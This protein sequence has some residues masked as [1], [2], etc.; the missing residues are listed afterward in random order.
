MNY[1]DLAAVPEILAVESLT[2][3]TLTVL[4][5][6]GDCTGPVKLRH[7]AQDLGFPKPSITR[8]TLSLARSKLVERRRGHDLRDCLLSLTHEG[9]TCWSKLTGEQSREA[10]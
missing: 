3:R 8:A 10:A 4:L 7:A 1:R 6:L 9:W 2:V 5:Y